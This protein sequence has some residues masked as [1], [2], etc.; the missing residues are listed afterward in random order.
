MA[1]ASIYVPDFSIQAVVRT[2]PPPQ[3]TQQR[4]VLGAPEPA[5]RQHAIALVEGHP[6]LE[7]VVAVNQA[8]AR[9]G[10]TLGMTKSQAKQFLST[11]IRSRSHVQEEITH[12]AL[13]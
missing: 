4:R 3:H 7:K 1:F 9:A 10:I 5:L 12:A 11:A 13:L 8:A 2:E 6:P